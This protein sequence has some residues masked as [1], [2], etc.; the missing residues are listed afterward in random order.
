[1]NSPDVY[2]YNR[3]IY[4][5]ERDDLTTPARTLPTRETPTT[6]SAQAADGTQ[7]QQQVLLNFG[8]IARMMADIDPETKQFL[9][10]DRK[11]LF[12][13]AVEGLNKHLRAAGL[14][15]AAL[16]PDVG[17][18]FRA[19]RLCPVAHARV[20][21]I[22][23]DPYPGKDEADGLSFSTR[24]KP[25]KL[26][27]S[28][29][30]IFNCLERHKLMRGP[31]HARTSGD[32]SSWARQGVLLL[33]T[34]LTTVVGQSGTH[35]P[36]WEAFTSDVIRAFGRADGRPIIF[37]L[38][39][40]HAMK[41]KKFVVGQGHVVLEWGHPSPVSTYNQTNNP[42]NFVNCDVFARVNALLVERG[43]PAI[44]WD[45]GANQTDTDDLGDLA[46]DLDI[47]DAV[48]S[49]HGMD[50]GQVMVKLRVDA[51]TMAVTPAISAATHKINP[52]LGDCRLWIFADGS[53]SQN[54]RKNC[55]CAW[56]IYGTDLKGLEFTAC[57]LVKEK[58]IGGEAYRASNNRAELSAIHAAL[59]VIDKNIQKNRYTGATIVSDSKYAI[60]SVT[61][62]GEKW[63]TGGF[64]D[65]HAKMNLDIILPCI[66][67][68]RAIRRGSATTTAAELAGPFDV[69]LAHQRGHTPEPATKTGIEWMMWYGNDQVDKL[70]RLPLT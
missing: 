34:A 12:I 39:G 24:A 43:Q 1:M 25:K 6:D 3:P 62:W 48:V 45:N 29:R 44:D 11:K 2:T 59:M 42:R 10:S 23:Q 50:I 47:S 67:L 38:L 32:L 36:I 41:Y 30:N 21:L 60:N 65:L 20:V 35:L 54:G 14:T 28:L 13:D 40:N 63:L 66:E 7:A 22:G 37:I 17:D 8:D 51:Q 61:T 70:C 49:L 46:E 53:A 55:K 4:P 57:D 27:A 68:L 52:K 69:Q 31:V 9:F 5:M 64:A 18:I 19:F 56:G 16:A 58:E 33:N 26:P 15:K